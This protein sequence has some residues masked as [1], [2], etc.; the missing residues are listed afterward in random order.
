MLKS[1]LKLRTFSMAGCVSIPLGSQQGGE[2]N[3]N[4]GENVAH[5]MIYQH[6][7]N[8]K[9][10]MGYRI[11]LVLNVDSRMTDW[12]EPVHVIAAYDGLYS[13]PVSDN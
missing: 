5:V 9:W 2:Y 11:S 13:L 4:K 6:N 10:T 8:H 1:S 12:L 3:Q 7:Y